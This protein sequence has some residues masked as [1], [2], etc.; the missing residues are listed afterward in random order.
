[1]SSGTALTD[2]TNFPALHAESGTTAPCENIYGLKIFYDANGNLCSILKQ[3]GSS[4]TSQCVYMSIRR[5][6]ESSYV[7]LY[8][9]SMATPHVGSCSTAVEHSELQRRERQDI[10]K[11]WSIYYCTTNCPSSFLTDTNICAL[12]QSVHFICPTLL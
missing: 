7:L 6:G 9:T 3:V 4:N 1:M 8:G 5:F 12:T 10:S 2:M 11:F